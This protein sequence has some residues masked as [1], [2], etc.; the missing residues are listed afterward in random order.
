MKGNWHDLESCISLTAFEFVN[1]FFFNFAK[2]ASLYRGIKREGSNYRIIKVGEDLQD[3]V[4][5][6][7]E[8]HLAKT[9]ALSA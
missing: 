1:D 4:Q 3:G 9:R 6:L 8:H 2:L 7:T 5:P